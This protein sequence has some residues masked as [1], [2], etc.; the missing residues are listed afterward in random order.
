MK[1]RIQTSSYSPR[2]LPGNRG[3]SLVEMAVTLGV[4]SLVL[5]V[6]GML[7][8]CGMR[9]FLIMGNCVTL[10]DK[11]RIAADQITRDLRQA[12]Q[13]LRYEADADGKRLVLTNSVQGVLVDYVWNAE[14]RTL[15]CEKTDQPQFTCLNDCDAWEATFFQN[16][17]L[18]S[19][20]SPYLPAT[21]VIGGADVNL[22]RIVSLSWKCS[23]PVTGSNTKTESAQTLQI[24]L[25]NAGQP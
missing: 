8:F 23:R 15:T 21:N 4:G 3:F 2:A 6:I 18:A 5:V 12:T 22:A 17:P 20:S 7:S 24:A 9:S 1:S 19:V 11:S 10:D 14:T 25:R 16:I 13:V